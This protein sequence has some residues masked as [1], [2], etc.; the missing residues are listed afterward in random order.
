MERYSAEG[1]KRRKG[2]IIE[3]ES[4]R[5]MSR[6]INGDGNSRRGRSGAARRGISEQERRE[7]AKRAEMARRMDESRRGSVRRKGPSRRR[8]KSSGGIGI[9]VALIAIVVV[10]SGFG[11]VHYKNQKEEHRLARAGVEYL[12]QGNYEAAVET[13][14]Q[15]VQKAGKRMGAYEKQVLGARAEAE[16]RVGDY[17]TALE[18]YQTLR[19][20]DAENET[21][22]KGVVLCLMEKKEYSSALELGV[23]QAQIYSRMATDQIEAKDYNGALTSVQQGQAVVGDDQRTAREL[24]YDEA[25]LWEYAG[26][27]GK[28][29][30]LFEDYEKTYGTDDE[31]SREITF[32]RSRQG[33]N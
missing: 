8:R 24:A 27:Y 4:A 26:D 14:N 33:N 13:L 9:L 30:E 2:S 19:K 3:L 18:T 10:C 31:V 21:Y 16:Y 11:L 12:N 23:L 17:D 7:Q 20:A 32:L 28:A 22:K 29:L 25:V 1:V 6:S 5:K 15:A